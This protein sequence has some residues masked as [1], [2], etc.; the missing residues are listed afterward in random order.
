M[1][2]LSAL[3]QK[4]PEPAP[5]TLRQ[6]RTVGSPY[7][8]SSLALPL[9]LRLGL[10][11]PLQRKNLDLGPS[12]ISF[13][14]TPPLVLSTPQAPSAPGVGWAT[15]LRQLPWQW[16]QHLP[17]SVQGL[18]V[19]PVGLGSGR[20]S[21]ARIL[22]ASPPGTRAKASFPHPMGARTAVFQDC[23]WLAA[24]GTAVSHLPDH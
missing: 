9:C 5:L 20:G 1:T 6:T 4:V 3:K 7:S 21:S 17:S 18:Q 24:V 23:S 15:L 8:L 14:L 22:P 19:P 12:E 2:N 16:A 11:S 10:W 13:L